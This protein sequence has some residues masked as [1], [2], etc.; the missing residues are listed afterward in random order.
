MSLSVPKADMRRASWV[1][2][3]ARH[4]PPLGGLGNVPHL[5]LKKNVAESRRWT[6]FT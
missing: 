2:Q 5:R 1:C 4:I 3:S 6:R